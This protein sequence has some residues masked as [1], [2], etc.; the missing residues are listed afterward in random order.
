MQLNQLV[1]IVIPVYNVRGYLARCV[2]SAL[3]QTHKN[4]L[5]WLVDDGSTDGSN[6]ICDEYAKRDTRV[7]ALH[8][9]NGGQASARNTAL[10]CIELHGDLDKE[11]VTFVDSDDWIEPDFVEFLLKLLLSSNAE[12]AQCGHYI[13]YSST[14]EVKKNTNYKNIELDTKEALESILRNGIWD[15]TVWNKMF[16]ASIF[17]RLRFPEVRYYEDTAFAPLL[18]ERLTRVIV[19]MEPKYHYVQ[20]YSSTANGTSWT[21]RKLDFVPIG[22]GVA[23]YILSVYPDL[24]KAALEKR[25]F[26]RLSTISQMVNA[27]HRDDAR[28]KRMREFILQHAR[29]M[30][31]DG[32]AS[33]RDKVGV[34][35]LL[36]GLGF[37]R[38]VWSLYYILR[39]RRAIGKRA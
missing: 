33:M 7:R 10:N 31:F 11:F 21:D 12:A 22:D 17:R 27:G 25:V 2:D 16:R 36:P 23:D 4:I 20:R 26:V 24:A 8:K 28:A 9:K 39:R 32:R 19:S 35:M 1:N 13:T 15:I 18:T 6:L 29:E 3:S 30:L 14:Y 38:L 37:Y 5:I 34:L